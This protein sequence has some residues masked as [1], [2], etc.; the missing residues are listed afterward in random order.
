MKVAHV[1]GGL[2]P[3]GAETLLARLVLRPSQLEHEVICLGPRDMH[4]SALEANGVSVHHLDLGSERLP[5]RK[6]MQVRTLLK[7]SG[8]DVVQGWMY[9]SNLVAGLFA[10]AGRIPAVWSIHCASLAP[11]DWSARSWVFASSLFSRLLPAAIINCSQRSIELHG[12][13]GFPQSLVRWVPNGYDSSAFYP[14]AGDRKRVRDEHGIAEREFVLGAVSRWHEEKDVPG[15]L[16]ALAKLRDAGE[17]LKC[18]LIGHLLDQDNAALMQAIREREL[19]D[20]V[21]PLGRRTDVAKLLRAVDLHVLASRS[22]SFPNVVGEAMLSGTPCVV[23]DVGDAAYIVGGEGWV[24]PPGSPELLAARI[25]EAH[26]MFV[27]EPSAW[28]RRR[29]AARARIVDDFG[30][31]RMAQAYEAIWREVARPARRSGA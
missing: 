26:R 13:L 29:E 23:T 20:L 8:A 12:R 14:D 16:T 10:R 30:L 18:L 5:A 2:G 9:R 27:E 4:S 17:P 25:G 19:Q 7:A 22:E 28:S 3:G 21:V 24:A 15:L 6:L 11:L 1:I 31:E